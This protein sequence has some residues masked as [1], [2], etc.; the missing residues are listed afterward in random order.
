MEA[1][2]ADLALPPRPEATRPEW[3]PTEEQLTGGRRLGALAAV[4]V[5]CV[6]VA[7]WWFWQQPVGWTMGA[8]GLLL[9]VALV[10]WERRLPRG[11]AAG[12]VAWG[13]IGLC[14]A[15]AEEPGVLT[16]LVGIVALSTLALTLRDGWA[17]DGPAWVGRWLRLLIGGWLCP[18]QDLRAWRY[19]QR[20]RTDAGGAG[21]RWLRNWLPPILLSGVFLVLFAVA[22]PVI[23]RWL[24]A[25][26]RQVCDFGAWL[27]DW[28]PTGGQLLLWL[29]VGA[30]TWALLRFRSGPWQPAP[31]A[32]ATETVPST[33]ASSSGVVVRC[34]LLFNALFAL[35]LG[36]DLRYLWGG[37]QLPAGMTYAHY[38]HRGAYPLVA[39]ALLAAVFVLLAFR[40][41]P[42]ASGMRAARRLVYL[43]LAQN[44]VLLISAA[45]RLWLYV[46]VYSLTRWRV[47]TAIWMLL[48]FGGVVWILVRIGAR[49]S[50]RW[51][52]NV[53]MATATVVLYLCC[54]G[55]FDGWI[56]RFNVAHCGE[57][58]GAG[59]PLDLAYLETLGP[60]A[61]PALSTFAERTG[62]TPRAQ[63][64]TDA[65]G[66][67]QQQLDDTLANWRGWTW[68]RHR[69]MRSLG[70]VPV[71][72]G[73]TQSAGG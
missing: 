42:R 55:N 27:S 1:P 12:M 56:A 62:G 40:G 4:C 52:I 58:T 48:V 39:V 19:V 70:S 68:R 54:F 44:A 23:T 41:D 20:H 61:L 71:I 53:N 46:G 16:A 37:A 24:E 22:N 13:V 25:I 65:M 63:E 45:W 7:N 28:T 26:W 10:A 66:R 59:E 32:A 17:A 72:G 14:L 33:A 31:S 57:F 47:A 36:L 11:R 43:W 21:E 15:C 38:A 51:L 64:A 18:L 6:V 49:R 60:A 5:G 69:L 30:G 35:Q 9:A 34:L 67:L 29:M 73:M 8:L 50:N 2:R 3:Q